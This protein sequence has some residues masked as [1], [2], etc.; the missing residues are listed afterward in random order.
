MK[1][2]PLFIGWVVLDETDR[3]ALGLEPWR[4]GWEVLHVQWFGQGFAIMAR[5]RKSSAV[6]R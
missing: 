4:H 5:P 6:G 1:A 3:I 2:G